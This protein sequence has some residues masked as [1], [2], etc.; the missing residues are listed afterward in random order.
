MRFC[1][2]FLAQMFKIKPD[3]ACGSVMLGLISP[4]AVWFAE[5]LKNI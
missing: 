3:L 4:Y 5:T 1:S 2:K